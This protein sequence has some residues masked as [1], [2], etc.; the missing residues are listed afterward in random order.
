MQALFEISRWQ[1]FDLSCST[2]NC[3]KDLELCTLPLPPILLHT[4]KI[5]NTAK[6]FNFLQEECWGSQISFHSFQLHE[7][8]VSCSF[9]FLKSNQILDLYS[10]SAIS[11]QI[12]NSFANKIKKN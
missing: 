4:F 8:S 6:N 3:L 9:Q 2:G 5:P 12:Q 7:S 10:F 11:K 1:I